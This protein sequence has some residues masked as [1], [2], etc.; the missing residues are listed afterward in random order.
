MRLTPLHRRGDGGEAH[1]SSFAT[2]LID[3]MALQVLITDFLVANYL[4]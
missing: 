2:S 3:N 1:S 4:E